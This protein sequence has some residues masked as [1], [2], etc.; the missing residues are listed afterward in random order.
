MDDETVLLLTA[1][2]DG[3]LSA[4]E[5][6]A[7]E[8]RLASEPELRALADDLHMLSAQ[9]KTVLP[10]HPPAEELRAR[11]ISTIG[12]V[13]EVA[14]AR[15]ARQWLSIA[16]S[17]LIGIFVGGA[18]VTLT[19]VAGSARR[20]TSKEIYAAHLRSLIAPQPFDIASSDRHVVKPWFNGK[21]AIAP[22]APDLT[23]AGFPLIG[24]RIDIVAG[25]PVPVLIY[26]HDQHIISVTAL[27]RQAG[28]SE[29]EASEGGSTIES[30]ILGGMTYWAVS[31]LNGADLRRF[32]GA[33]KAA[34]Q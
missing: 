11:V 1:Y 21:T 6:L 32:V 31:D 34:S 29:D 20:E 8:R 12:F 26:R 27:L 2:Q 13:D 14:T 23:S 25:V 5:T 17:L 4:S 9:L 7:M 15:P 18:L 22:S 3:E 30:W 28:M 24:G 10:G 33:F 19:N 16:A